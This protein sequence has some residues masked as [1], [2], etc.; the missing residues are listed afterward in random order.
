M[1][2]NAVTLL[3]VLALI[4]FVACFFPQVPEKYVGAVGGVLLAIAV[5]VGA[6]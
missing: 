2:F 5:L 1:E 4:A 6:T 3:A